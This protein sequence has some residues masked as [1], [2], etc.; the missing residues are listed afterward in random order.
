MALG[1]KVVLLQLKL[2]TEL[3]S[4]PLPLRP[5]VPPPPVLV[6]QCH[7]AS[8]PMCPPPPCVGST[9][10]ATVLAMV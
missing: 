8:A 7:S 2:S 1:T 4:L 6:L 10:R 5:C 3:N 9:C